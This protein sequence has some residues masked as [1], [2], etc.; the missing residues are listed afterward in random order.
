MSFVKKKY[1]LTSLTES[2]AKLTTIKSSKYAE[3]ISDGEDEEGSATLR[4]KREEKTKAKYPV[5]I[6]L[7]EI[8]SSLRFPMLT[9]VGAGLRS[10]S[11]VGVEFWIYTI[12]LYVELDKLKASQALQEHAKGAEPGAAHEHA[13]FCRALI[14]MKDVTRVLRFVITLSGLKAAI[15]VAQFDKVLLPKMK[16]KGKEENYRF[17]MEN[18]GKAKFRKGTVMFLAL[19][20]NGTVTCICD[21][22]VLGSVT[23][24]VLCES[25]MDIYF[26]EKPI[27]A[28]VKEKICNGIHQES[29]GES[30]QESSP[31]DP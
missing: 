13:P 3:P 27:S 2:L 25:I 5:G 23:C 26:G 10:E 20:G 18:M 7:N 15:V 24:P 29:I 12:G 28:D 22:E 21:E 16:K 19:S 1:S 11:F 31:V 6:D 8:D 17:I 4:Y 9:F 14:D 30:S